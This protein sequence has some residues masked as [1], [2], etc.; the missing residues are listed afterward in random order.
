VATLQGGTA[1]GTIYISCP[2]PI[3]YM[4]EASNSMRFAGLS[5]APFDPYGGVPLAQCRPGDIAPR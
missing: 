3:V 2:A 5:N 1:T 4:N